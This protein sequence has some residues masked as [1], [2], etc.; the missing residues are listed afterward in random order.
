MHADDLLILNDI[1]V[2]GDYLGSGSPSGRTVFDVIA[3][4]NIINIV[5][6]GG[7]VTAD[8]RHK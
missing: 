4:I 5:L 6:S 1:S 3:L 8:D 2:D 7:A